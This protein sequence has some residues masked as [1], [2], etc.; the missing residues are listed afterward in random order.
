MVIY[1]VVVLE[2]VFLEIVNNTSVTK[3]NDQNRKP[4]Q[5]TD[6]KIIVFMSNTSVILVIKCRL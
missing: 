4:N 1:S 5:A 2:F 3:T 6:V